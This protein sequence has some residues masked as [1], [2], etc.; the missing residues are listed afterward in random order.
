MGAETTRMENVGDGEGE[1]VKEGGS[2][3]NEDNGSVD[4]EKATHKGK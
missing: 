3:A 4:L 2:M 1:V